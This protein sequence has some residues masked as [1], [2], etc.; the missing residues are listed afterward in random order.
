MAK[1][2]EIKVEINAKDFKFSKERLVKSKKLNADILSVI[3][4]DGKEYT[5][6]EVA[7]LVEKFKNRKVK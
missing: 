5:L 2:N 7:N 1:K 4:E 3:L 6:D